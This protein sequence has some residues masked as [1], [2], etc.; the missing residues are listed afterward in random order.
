MEMDTTQI[1]GVDSTSRHQEAV[2]SARAKL[3]VRER[4][5]T[6]GYQRRKPILWWI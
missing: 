1:G 2:L 5:L 6:D 3:L 4:I